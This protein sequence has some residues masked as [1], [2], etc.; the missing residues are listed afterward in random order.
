MTGPSYID[1]NIPNAPNP[2]SLTPCMEPTESLII[3]TDQKN[4]LQNP[5]QTEMSNITSKESSFTTEHDDKF[6]LDDPEIT[7]VTDLMNDAGY[8]EDIIP[9]ESSTYCSYIGE[10]ESYYNGNELKT[11][12]FSKT[13]KFVHENPKTS[14]GLGAAVLALGGAII[15]NLKKLFTQQTKRS[16]TKNQINQKYNQHVKNKI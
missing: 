8:K 2:S 12:I 4:T 7:L 9:T 1:H 16:Q 6:E 10:P 3:N 14:V 5:H 15:Y 13:K 11:T